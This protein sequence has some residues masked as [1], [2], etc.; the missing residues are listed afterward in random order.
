MTARQFVGKEIRLAR[1][2]KGLSRV[3]LAKKFPVSE[4]LVR[5]WES[6]RTAPGEQCVG[7]LITILD[8][9]EM[10]QHV[11]DDLACNEV[12][13]E[14]LG[15]WLA[16]EEKATTLLT[17]EPLVVPG[18]LQ[19]E[20]YARAVLR[21]GKESPLDLEGKVNDRLGRQRVLAR[22]EPPLYHAILDEAAIT[23]PVGSPQIMCDQLMH[24]ADQAEQREMIIV[25]VIPFRVGA[26]AGFAGGAIVLASFDG[27][28]VA[29]VDNAL[30]GDVIEKSEDVMVIRRLW[31]KL[32]AKALSE[33]ESALLIRE[34]ARKWAT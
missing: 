15:K 8:L 24:V 13:P 22:E 3:E 31:Q 10:L 23:R 32:S 18:L 12:A 30:R 19:T 20:D 9:P 7:K 33:D 27:A 21:L 16:V 11:L 17:F 1:E 28:E 14:W 26:H 2:A 34:A 29:Y 5:W 6:G 4:S 25:Q